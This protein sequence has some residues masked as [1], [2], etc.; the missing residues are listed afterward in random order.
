MSKSLGT[1]RALGGDRPLRRDALRCTS[2]LKQPWDGYRFSL[3]T[4]GE[5][6][7]QFL[8]QLWNTYA[9]Y[10]LYANANGIDPPS[11]PS[12]P[13][14]GSV[15]DVASAGDRRDRSRPARRFRPP[16]PGGRS[17]RSST[18]CPTGTCAVRAG[19]SG[20]RSGGVRDAAGVP[21]DDRQAAW[22]RSAVHR[23]R[24]S[25]TT[26]WFR[27][28]RASVRLPVPRRATRPGAGDASGAGDRP[29]GPGRTRSGEDQGSQPCGRR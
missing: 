11:P 16:P 9:F 17:S 13:A 14:T 7:R 12:L 25:S 19:A 15:G 28:E 26:R 24:I 4:I 23:R 18:S 22:R 21:G 27:A 3:E 29:A 6:V 1:R 5:A 2:S 20:T 8:L 10:V